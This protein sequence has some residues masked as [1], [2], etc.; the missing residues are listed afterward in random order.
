M[1][2]KTDEIKYKSA[3]EVLKTKP[4]KPDT[5]KKRVTLYIDYEIYALF[6][7][8]CFES[9]RSV[10]ELVQSMMSDVLSENKQA[11]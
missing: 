7:K 10:S 4:Q 11:S 8:L 5:S 2:G 9:E 6:Q 1:A 3:R